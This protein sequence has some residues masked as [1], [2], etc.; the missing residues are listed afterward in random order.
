MIA[1]II[2]IEKDNDFKHLI[3]ITDGCVSEEDIKNADIEMNKIKNNFEYVTIFILG[4]GDLSI[5]APFCRNTPNKTYFKEKL[6]SDFK[7]LI[8]LNKE[9]IKTLEEIDKFD[10]YNDF[11]NN[12]VRIFNA[13][14]AKCIGTKENKELETKLESI[15]SRIKDKKNIDNFELFTKKTNS[16]ISMTKGSLL[17]T[18]TLEKISAAIS[19]YEQ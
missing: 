12:Y 7:E 16:L 15:I 8:T 2:E 3:I 6:D 17:N 11:M 13:V 1:K 5:G 19:N 14:K 9:D 18:F 10:N 4:N